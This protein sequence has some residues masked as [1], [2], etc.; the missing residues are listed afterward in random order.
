MEEA[1][2]QS[3]TTALLSGQTYKKKSYRYVREKVNQFTNLNL[4]LINSLESD[5]PEYSASKFTIIQVHSI[6]RSFAGGEGGHGYKNTEDSGS[7]VSST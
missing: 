3:T 4:P 7:F 5:K 1:W 2:A 6:R